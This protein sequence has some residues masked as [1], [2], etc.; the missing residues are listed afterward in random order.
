VRRKLESQARRYSERRLL[1]CLG[2]IQQTDLAL[3]GAGGLRP[4]LALERLVMGLAA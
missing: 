4:E 2:A 1:T 3:K